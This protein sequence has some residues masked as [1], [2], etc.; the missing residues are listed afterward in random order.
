VKTPNARVLIITKKTS[1]CDISFTSAADAGGLKTDY[2]RNPYD[3]YALSRDQGSGN[4]G[5]GN[6][7]SGNNVW[8]AVLEVAS[9]SDPKIWRYEGVGWSAETR[10]E[11][12]S[13]YDR[14][15]YTGDSYKI[16][17]L[18]ANNQVTGS[19]TGVFKQDWEGGFKYIF[20]S[21]MYI[22][23]DIPRDQFYESMG[24]ENRPAIQPYCNRQG[25][26]L[27]QDVQ[28]I[29]VK[30]SR[31]ALAMVHQQPADLDECNLAYTAIGFGFGGSEWCPGWTAGALC[32]GYAEYDVTYN[33][34]QFKTGT[35]T[36]KQAGFRILAKFSGNGQPAHEQGDG[37]P[38]VDDDGF[39]LAMQ[40]S[41]KSIF[42]FDSHYW[43]DETLLGRTGQG[44]SDRDGKYKPFIDVPATEIK[45]C[46]VGCVTLVIPE[47]HRGQTLNEIFSSVP[48]GPQGLDFDHPQGLEFD[49]AEIEEFRA[50]FGAPNSNFPYQKVKLNFDDTDSVFQCKGRIALIQNQEHTHETANDAIGL[51]AQDAGGN[52]AGA[53]V[54]IYDWRYKNVQAQLYV[55]GGPVRHKLVPKSCY[56]VN[57][58]NSASNTKSATVPSKFRCP[59]RVDKSNWIE[60]GPS[61][62]TFSVTQSGDTVTATRTDRNHAWGTQLAFNCCVD[63][64]AAQSTMQKAVAAFQ[65]FGVSNRA[66]MG[67]FALIGAI[68]MLYHAVKGAHKMVFP[69]EFQ[70]ISDEMEI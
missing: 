63:G 24:D 14:P 34:R 12:S 52:G 4:T 31:F 58:C 30:K 43:T 35:C 26:N 2:K 49:Q 45:I 59:T 23:T 39:Q 69:S 5:S 37:R 22:E 70:K 19:M 46:S 51:G 32:G 57:I 48:S 44:V 53:A 7:G 28:P 9:G 3:H 42:K 55:R 60:G 21:D 38:F 33:G 68:T 67:L 29:T 8:E 6:T 41:H 65:V 18:D 54:A 27:K 62:D 20:Q 1:K 13:G 56:K 40:F 47:S 50:A 61:G 66:I 11:R 64:N 10:P 17:M 36:N 16:E 25:F 15:L